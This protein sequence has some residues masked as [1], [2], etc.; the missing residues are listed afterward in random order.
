MFPQAWLRE[1]SACRG[2]SQR[3]ESRRH[4]PQAPREKPKQSREAE[5]FV[6]F[7]VYCHSDRFPKIVQ[8]GSP[9]FF[10]SWSAEQ[11]CSFF[12]PCCP[13]VP[14]QCYVCCCTVYTKPTGLTRFSAERIS[15]ARLGL[16]AKGQPES[17]LQFDK[18][19]SFLTKSPK[20]HAFVFLFHM[21]WGIIFPHFD[22]RYDC[23]YETVF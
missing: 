4:E 10:P 18:T 3:E 11:Y 21:V 6:L 12:P 22:R 16:F 13:S 7:P 5:A 9:H 1:R 19:P 23:R 8:A 17:I 2:R 15:S 20:V 14:L